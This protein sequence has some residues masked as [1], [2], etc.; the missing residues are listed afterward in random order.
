MVGVVLALLLVVKV[1]DMGFN[2]VMDRSFDPV[3]DWAYFGPGFGVLGDSIGRS[4]AVVTAVV[5]GLVVVALLVVMPLSVGRLARVAHRH[6][7]TSVRALV[8]LTVVWVLCSVAG[9]QFVRGGPVASYAA[10]RLAYGEVTQVQAGIADR[11]VFAREI[12]RDELADL[13]PGRL[14]TGLRGKDVLVLFVESYGRVAVQGSDFSPEIDAVLDNGTSRLRGAGYSARSG[15]LTSPTFGAASW[16]AHSSLQSGL[17]VDSQRRYNQL[18]TED[19]MTL[20]SA[21]EGAGWR[22][23]FA[24]PANTKPWPEGS[25]YYGFDELYD[26]TTIPYAGPKFGYAHVPDQYTLAAFRRLELARRDRPPVMAEID[27]ESSHHPWAPLPRMLDWHDLG[28][29]SVYDGMPEEGESAE[30]VFRDPDAVRNAYGESIEYTLT[31][32][33]SFLETYPDP[34]LVVV[35]RRRPPAALLRQRRRPRPRRPHLRDRPGSVGDGADLLLGLAGRPQPVAVRPRLA[36]GPVPRPLPHGLQSRTRPLTSGRRRVRRP[37]R[38]A[39]RRLSRDRPRSA[40]RLADQEHGPGDGGRCNHE[41]H[42]DQH[43][44]SRLG[45]VG[46]PRG[47]ARPSSY[48]SCSVSVAHADPPPVAEAS[49]SP[50]SPS[51]GWTLRPGTCL[52]APPTGWPSRRNHDRHVDQ[53]P[54]SRLGQ[55]GVPSARPRPSLVLLLLGSVAHADPPPVAEA[56][57]TPH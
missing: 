21:F 19:R 57:T 14:L 45:Q 23:V 43:P 32:V 39:V 33:F 34:N 48:C 8:A 53:H 52:H 49:D 6:R 17:W 29:G 9:L 36:D 31:S 15:F 35:L 47:R 28:D 46:V 25:A 30:E 24:V 56:I 41:R 10:A 40:V 3:N 42:E 4:G 20:T 50:V 16:L 44:W 37:S 11:D 1:L 55:V 13:P 22:T 54:W 38:P 27:L 5:V 18:F 2:E 51:T 26:S 12:R 7:R